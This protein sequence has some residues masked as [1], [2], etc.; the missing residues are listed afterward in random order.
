MWILIAYL[1]VYVVQ[2]IRGPSTWD[3]LLGLNLVAT[4]IVIVIIVFASMSDTAYLLDFA[5]IY[6][7]FGFIGTIFISLFMA[8]IKGKGRK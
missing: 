8:S 5:I 3:R 7:L 6:A 2:I 4:K 1:C